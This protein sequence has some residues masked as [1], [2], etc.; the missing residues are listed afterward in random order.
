VERG[1]AEHQRLI[2][3]EPCQLGVVSTE[4]LTSPSA[5]A[6]PPNR[7]RPVKTSTKWTHKAGEFGSERRRATTVLEAVAQLANNSDIFRTWA[8]KLPHANAAQ[9]G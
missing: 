9:S 7:G 6:K 2:P 3:R 1:Q 8:I 4:C 5:T